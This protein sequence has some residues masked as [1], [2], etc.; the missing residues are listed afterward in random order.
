MLKAINLFKDKTKRN[1]SEKKKKL[2]EKSIEL[3]ENI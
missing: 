2:I 1:K 3:I